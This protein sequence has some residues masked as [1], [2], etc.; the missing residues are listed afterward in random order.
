MSQ[1]HYVLCLYLLIS[2]NVLLPIWTLGITSFGVIL[3]KIYSFIVL[4]YFQGNF[5]GEG[6]LRDVSYNIHLAHA[7]DVP[8]EC[9][10]SALVF[11][12]VIIYKRMMLF[13]NNL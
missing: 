6:M 2:K 1:T 10:I 11:A 8:E 5:H 9:Q 12:L 13:K 4:L 3:M 7:G